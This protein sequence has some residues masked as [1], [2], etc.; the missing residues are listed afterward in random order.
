MSPRRRAIVLLTLAAVL[1]TLAASDVSR[2]EAALRRGLGLQVPVVVARVGLPAGTKLDAGHL[3]VRRV[4]ARFAPQRVFRTG[5]QLLGLRTTVAVPAGADLQP[6]LVSAPGARDATAGGVPLA[7]GQRVVPL[8]AGGSA[9]EIVV[10]SH[11]DVVITRGDGATDDAKTT[12]VD[13]VEVL[14][15]AAAPTNGSGPHVAVALRVSLRQAVLLAGA[16]TAAT[17][18]RLLVRPGQ[19]P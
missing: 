4:P 11:V 6:E 13:D 12:V 9:Q 14:R 2:R 3:S 5:E 8:V 19:G 17:D 16:Q 15:V 7:P 18:I 1:G 10:G